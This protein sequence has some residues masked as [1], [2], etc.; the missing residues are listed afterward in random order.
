M[1]SRALSPLLLIL[2]VLSVAA[3]DPNKYF[4]GIVETSGVR[5][6]LG[7][8]AQIA[9]TFKWSRSAQG[10]VPDSGKATVTDPSI[11][12]TMENNSSPVRFTGAQAQYFNPSTGTVSKSGKISYTAA[13]ASAT[14]LPVLIQ[15]T[16][17]D[18]A[19]APESVT[20]KLS[21]LVTQEL[22]G[23][24]DPSGATASAIPTITAEVKLIG[25]NDLGVKADTTLSIPINVIKTITE[26][27]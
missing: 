25:N 11:V 18:R 16:Q 8:P 9:W 20:V 24:T 10:P 12:M 15:L 1:K 21:G 6:T 13:F 3:C 14:V 4:A 5:A 22:L 7:A 23:L 27:D 2:G 17:K 26:V 19:T